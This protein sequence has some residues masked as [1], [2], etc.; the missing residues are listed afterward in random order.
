[1]N[2]DK[3]IILTHGRAGST[4]L[5]QLLDS[6]PSITCYE[7]IFNVSNGN[8]ES[9]YYFCKLHYPKL[10]YFFLRGK[11]SKSSLNFPLAFLVQQYL[12]HVYGAAQKNKVGFKLIY[13]QMLYYRPLISWITENSIPVIHLHRNNYLKAAMSLIIARDTGVYVTSS[14]SL[15]KSQKIT[16]S[17]TRLFHGVNNL[18]KD[19]LQCDLLMRNNPSLTVNYEDLFDKQALIIQQIVDFLGISNPFFQTPDIVKTNPEKI[20]ELVENY[21]E[22]RQAFI[23]T[24]WEK[25]LD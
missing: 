5:Q 4:F 14:G 25:Y 21:E 23:G 24:P 8:H 6:H 12:K 18:W 10:S 11:I 3:F 13:D 20:S 15:K 7:E 22:V 9:F 1:M 2:T 17:P 19:K 16:V